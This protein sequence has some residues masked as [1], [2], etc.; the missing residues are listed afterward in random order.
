MSTRK[1]RKE[2]FSVYTIVF[3]QLRF[4]TA[5]HLP[6]YIFRNHILERLGLYPLQGL[7]AIS[8]PV[9]KFPGMEMILRLNKVRLFRAQL[10]FAGFPFESEAKGDNIIS[11]HQTR[12]VKV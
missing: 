1:K 8:N 5:M 2:S 7:A 11:V 4:R 9:L 12:A 10:T 3:G 6:I